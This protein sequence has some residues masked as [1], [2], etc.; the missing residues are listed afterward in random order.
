MDYLLGRSGGGGQESGD[1]IQGV[2]S[3]CPA[4]FTGHGLM[5]R[6]SS[7]EAAPGRTLCMTIWKVR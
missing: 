1:A 4:R 7:Y 5:T 2:G 3:Q 6:T